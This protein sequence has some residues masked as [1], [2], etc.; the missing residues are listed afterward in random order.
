[1]RPAWSELRAGIRLGAVPTAT[2]RV[3]AQR[4]DCEDCDGGGRCVRVRPVKQAEPLHR[5]EG[6]DGAGVESNGIDG[7]VALAEPDCTVWVADGWRADLH[8]VA[9]KLATHDGVALV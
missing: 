9:R 2:A 1:M 3:Q 4:A 7:P 5:P 8:E 6:V